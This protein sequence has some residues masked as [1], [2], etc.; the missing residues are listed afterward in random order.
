MVGDRE[1]HLTMC[2][3]NRGEE[4]GRCLEIGQ[5]GLAAKS[6]EQSLLVACSRGKS[7]AS[8]VLLGLLRNDSLTS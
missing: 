6:S 3:G 5:S 1:Q 2:S 7:A 4:A 8:D